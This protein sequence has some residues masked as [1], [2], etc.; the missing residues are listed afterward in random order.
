[1]DS[2]TRPVLKA[3][4]RAG[5]WLLLGIA[6]IAF[7]MGGRAISEFAKVDRIL[8]EFLGLLVA[9]VTGIGGYLLK[10]SADDLDGTEDPQ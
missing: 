10:T 7:W 4:L 8:A 9:V 5:S 1:M 2:A 6:G 3:F